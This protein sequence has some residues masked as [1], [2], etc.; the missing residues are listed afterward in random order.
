MLTSIRI[1]VVFLITITVMKAHGEDPVTWSSAHAWSVH[2]LPFRDGW[3]LHQPRTAWATS[4][5]AIKITDWQGK[6]LAGIQRQQ[7]IMD[8][9]VW[10]NMIVAVQRTNDAYELL[11]LDQ[12]LQMKE[13]CTLA[14]ISS[15][16]S[17][18]RVDIIASDRHGKIFIRLTNLVVA[19]DLNQSPLQSIAMEEGVRGI[20][21]VSS[22]QGAAAIVHDVGGVAFVAVIDTLMK[23]RIAPAVS[24]APSSRIVE[25]GD[26]LIVLSPIDAEK[27]T[28][29][30]LVD[31]ASST[32]QAMHLGAALDLVDVLHGRDQDIVARVEL[33][34]GKF[35]LLTSALEKDLGSVDRTTI[36]PSEFGAPI[37][38]MS[39]SDT[40]FILFTGG[41]VTCTSGGDILSRDAIT[42][43][44][45][46]PT[47]RILRTERGLLVTSAT[48]ATL[49]LQGSHSYWWLARAFKS[50][51]AFAVP[52]MMAIIILYLLLR[53]RRQKRFLDATLE[54]PGA[55][56]VFVVDAAGRLTR[57]NER[58]AK[59]LRI[60]NRV[61]M[62]RSFH[63]YVQH[64]GVEGVRW[65]L[66]QSYADRRP[67]S[68]KVTVDDG[69][70]MREY[71]FTAQPLFGTFGRLRGIVVTGVDITEAL[72][73][74]RLV[75]WAQLAHDMQT[76]LSTIRLNAE[77]L[78]A[79][80]AAFVSDGPPAGG[81][82]TIDEGER[83]K[84]ILFQTRILIQR[85]RDLVSVGRSEELV[86]SLVHSAE[87]CTE[88][89][90]EF[91]PQMFPNVSFVMKL[92]GTMMNVDRLKLSRAVRNAVENAI[93]SLRGKPG[94]VEIATW[95]DRTNIYIRISDTGVGMD[96]LTLE[97]MMKPYFTTAKD[98][99]GTGIGT[100]IMQ[101]VT[102]L[103]G[104]ALRVTSEPGQGT[105]VVFR[106]PHH[107]E[108]IRSTP[109]ISVE[110]H[111]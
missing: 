28:Q 64:S 75:N 6:V 31:P 10:R 88:I 66:E 9:A 7:H 21:A 38:T 52:V 98:G 12:Q 16:E 35:T 59:L 78:E 80:R 90:H 32:T 36:L 57:T 46:P 63:S 30:T 44:V 74:R 96:T 72:E 42:M 47:A 56:L 3:V 2:V 18:D 87:F 102:N 14:L 95:A 26:R 43:K 15:V 1:I 70:E 92:R 27:G 53:L 50:V 99:S 22:D 5:P 39:V 33:I 84:R 106:I 82:R 65:F 4:D 97:N 41:V 62:G 25:I 69:D 103:H 109:A 86:R 85:V 40:I 93:K 24:L 89:R 13:R 110:E 94:T 20:G 11:M 83:I 108:G 91:D 19:V 8:V 58:G 77:Q 51:G 111:A 68:E 79:Q 49:L 107:M 37:R 48:G 104:G 60:G 100:M 67:M 76:N 55:G 54:L 17:I 29:V 71:V 81:I 45:D 73:R 61:P 34:D 101:H 105:Q 23:R